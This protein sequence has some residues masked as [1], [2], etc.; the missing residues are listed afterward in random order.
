[1]TL[2]DHLNNIYERKGNWDSLNDSDKKTWDTFMVNRYVSMLG[3]KECSLVDYIQRYTK[4][5]PKIVY[6]FYKSYFP[7]QKRFAQYV[8]GSKKEKVNSDLVK[9]LANVYECSTREVL[10]YVDIFSK[11]QLIELLEDLGHDTREIK[12]LIK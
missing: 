8:K 2:F 7:K 1:M 5:E 11:E 3:A 4:L 9:I 10:E 12:K 6:T